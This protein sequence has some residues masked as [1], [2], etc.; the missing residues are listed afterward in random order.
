MPMKAKIK[1]YFF[2]IRWWSIGHYH[3]DIPQKY[4]K[5]WWLMNRIFWIGVFLSMAYTLFVGILGYE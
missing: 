5:F 1:Y 3:C 2:L 4:K